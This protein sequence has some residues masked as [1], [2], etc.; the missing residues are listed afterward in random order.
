MY[1]FC[2]WFKIASQSSV[3]SLGCTRRADFNSDLKTIV[4]CEVGINEHIL[5]DVANKMRP[6]NEHIYKRTVQEIY[7]T[8]N[9]KAISGWAYAEGL[10]AERRSEG[11]RWESRRSQ[12]GSHSGPE[13][14]K[15][16]QCNYD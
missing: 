1:K 3:N 15:S 10:Q 2:A 9:L 13:D 16:L 6:C 4:A 11:P 14:E 8:L 5:T 12:S 7:P